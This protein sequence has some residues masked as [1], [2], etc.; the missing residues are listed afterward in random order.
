MKSNK[1][2][3]FEISV[4]ILNHTGVLL[5]TRLD[6]FKP[7][8]ASLSIDLEQLPPL[9]A[10]TKATEI[11]EQGTAIC[12]K[13]FPNAGENEEFNEYRIILKNEE[14]IEVL[15]ETETDE[16]KDAMDITYTIKPKYTRAVTDD[17]PRM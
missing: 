1:N 16:E 8:E 10:S 4:W 9:E 5:F 7:R 6:E 11:L 2:P 15:T 12:I 3:D 14:V 17:D 13:V